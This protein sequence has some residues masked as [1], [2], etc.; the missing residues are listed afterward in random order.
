MRH[1]YYLNL[2]FATIFFVAG[3]ATYGKDSPQSAQNLEATIGRGHPQTRRQWPPPGKHHIDL[4]IKPCTRKRATEDDIAA[5]RQLVQNAQVKQGVKNHHRFKK[6]LRAKFTLRPPPKAPKNTRVSTLATDALADSNVTEAAALIAEYEAPTYNETLPDLGPEFPKIQR[7]QNAG[8][9]WMEGVSHGAVAIGGSSGYQ[10]FRN[11]KDFGAVGD[12]RTDDTAAINLAISSGDR[13][14]ANCGSSTVKP[15]LVYFPS[16]T[17]LVSKSIIGYY[18]TQLVG[19][20]NNLPI[21]RASSSFIGLGVISSNVYIEGQDGAEW[22]INQNNFMRQVRN[23]I[24]DMRAVPNTMQGQSIRP[25]GIH[26]QVA[27]ATSLQNIQ[28]IMSSRADTTHLGIFME[29]GSGGFMSDMTFSGGAIGA[30]LGNQQFTIRKFSFNGCKVAVETHWNWALSAKSF[31][32]NNCQ[33]GFNISASAG[34]GQGTG[35][36][37]IMDSIVMNTPVGIIAT[38][39]GTNR[40]SIM[41]DNWKMINVDS[42]IVSAGKVVLAGGTGVIPSWGS[43]ITYNSA[44]EYGSR[45]VAQDGGS[46]ITGIEKPSALLGDFGNW[47]ERSKPQYE[48]LS[49]SAFYDVKASGARGNGRSDD[50]AAINAA[51]QAATSAG[52]IAYFPHGVYLVTDTIFIPPGAKVVGE[53]WSQIQGTGAKFSNKDSPY[54]MVK[55]GNA[56]DVGDVEIQD[57]LFGVRG[58]TAGAVL[59]QWNIKAGAPGSA[60]LWDSHW[61]VGGSIGSN[62]QKAQCPKLTGQVNPNCIAGSLLLH[63]TPTSS[64][65]FENAWIWTADHDLDVVTQD[66]IDIYVARGVLVESQGPSWFYGTA[67]EHNVLY[68]YQLQGAKNIFM[69]L[70]QTESPYFQ[71]NP[72]APTPFLPVWNADADGP[73]HKKRNLVVR[74]ASSR[75]SGDLN[76]TTAGLGR[77]GDEDG[78]TGQSLGSDPRFFDCVADPQTCAVSWAVRFIRSEDVHIYGAGLYSWF[79]NYNQDCLKSSQC[80]R[81]VAKI[82]GESKNLRLNNLITVGSTLMANDAAGFT[83]QSDKNRNGFASSILGV[84]A[85]D[86]NGGW[87]WDSDASGLAPNPNSTSF[88]GE[89]QN[90]VVILSTAR[91][92]PQWRTFWEYYMFSGQ[93]GDV[94]TNMDCDFILGADPSG[95]V[96]GPSDPNGLG[97]QPF[98]GPAKRLTNI[99]VDGHNCIYTTTSTTNWNDIG[100][101]VKF[102][103]L[104]CEG[105]LGAFDCFKPTPS[106]TPPKWEAK[107]NDHLW[108]VVGVECPTREFRAKTKRGLPPGVSYLRTSDLSVNYLTSTMRRFDGSFQ[109]DGGGAPKPTF[110]QKTI[111]LKK[112]EGFHG[113]L[114]YTQRL[115]A[116][117]IVVRGEKRPGLSDRAR[118][119]G[120]RVGLL[121]IW[122][123]WPNPDYDRNRFPGRNFYGLNDSNNFLWLLGIVHQRMYFAAM[124]AA[125]AYQ[126]FG[127]V[128]V[129]TED[130]A[131]IVMAGIW[132]DTEYPILTRPESL[133]LKII[134]I[135]RQGSNPHL[136]Y[137][138]GFPWFA[139][140][141]RPFPQDESALPWTH[142]I[143]NLPPD[144]EGYPWRPHLRDLTP[145]KRNEAASAHGD[146]SLIL[147]DTAVKGDSP[148]IL[149]HEVLKRRM[150]VDR[151]VTTATSNQSERNKRQL[152][153]DFEFPSVIYSERCFSNDNGWIEN[154]RLCAPYNRQFLASD[155]EREGYSDNY[156]DFFVEGPSDK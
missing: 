19:N 61:R 23:F 93:Y 20:P 116:N 119:L 126:G 97:A 129:M 122:E 120:A 14:G 48:H 51:L 69:G 125:F 146:N 15:A 90:R 24:I 35:S 52:K 13:C 39:T 145:R 149:A 108:F 65:Y 66:Q 46:I 88:G 156:A 128:Y 6:P 138:K 136:I 10:V 32:V 81:N 121:T 102:G 155:Y 131:H 9:F 5:A 26:W 150:R 79:Q 84:E 68:Q 134:A 54:I 45:G 130:P 62:L 133:V 56:G 31:L 140:P 43:G 154:P 152:W 139:S 96:E 59:V 49:S 30:Y 77:R 153:D 44:A 37:T 1:L 60:A 64:G 94:L 115:L 22:Y 98:K 99:V 147:N 110:Y 25:A 41:I 111:S 53:V 42:G 100:P 2:L 78:L 27:Q 117:H 55:V 21:I 29:N 137:L 3:V 123:G 106:V 63:L 103:E 47:F 135:D 70:I 57:M 4:P 36:I 83:I 124:S 142:P 87:L 143:T 114:F 85:K 151:E 8:A 73:T 67:S 82:D 112:N 38:L 75:A 40:T 72:M 7:R 95:V 16:G 113:I 107:C 105:F 12:G 148:P 18:N 127:T 132:G 144:H 109:L 58:G 33:I 76:S 34:S 118:N 28:V 91:D 89:D 80:Q 86:A 74:D 104:N 17:Y 101:G 71:P 92:G 50:T 11:V 141:S